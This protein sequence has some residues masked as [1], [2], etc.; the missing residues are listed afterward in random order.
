[1]YDENT[2][3]LKTDMFNG[4]DFRMKNMLKSD[5]QRMEYFYKMSLKRFGFFFKL[6]LQIIISNLTIL[7]QMKQNNAYFYLKCIKNKAK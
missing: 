7:W 2:P 6:I 5:W 1:M 4:T 3:I